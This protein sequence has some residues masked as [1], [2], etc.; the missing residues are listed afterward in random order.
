MLNT[1]MVYVEN[2]P[3]ESTY[4]GGFA[5][6]A[7]CSFNIDSLTVGPDGEDRKWS[8]MTITVDARSYQAK[9]N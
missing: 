7:A 5:V 6:S 2:K 8:R 3:R 1:F 9:R 4:A